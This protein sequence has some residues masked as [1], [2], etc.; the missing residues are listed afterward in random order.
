MPFGC[1]G[2]IMC[3]IE[4]GYPAGT[5]F[6]VLQGPVELVSCTRL[7]N[8]DNPGLLI[9]QLNPRSSTKTKQAIIKAHCYGYSLIK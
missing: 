8:E 3:T 7:S 1:G 4:L 9:M 6:R 5:P 2:C